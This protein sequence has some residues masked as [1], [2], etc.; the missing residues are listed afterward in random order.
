MK[1]LFMSRNTLCVQL[2]INIV[3]IIVGFIANTVAIRCACN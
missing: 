1:K 3:L 2:D